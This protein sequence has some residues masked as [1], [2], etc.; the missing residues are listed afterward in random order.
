MP[1]GGLYDA[2]NDHDGCGVALVAR[3]GG[4]PRREVVV[5][6]LES[7]RNLEHRGAEG[8][9]ADTGGGAGI[10]VQVPDGFSPAASG[11]ACPRSAA[12]ACSSRSF[13]ASHAAAARAAAARTSRRAEHPRL[14]R[15]PL[16][17]APR[18]PSRARLRAG[19]RSAL[20]RGFRGHRRHEGLRAT[21]ARRSPVRRNC[22]GRGAHRPELLGANHQL[23]GP[24]HGFAARPLL[25]RFARPALRVR[26][27]LGPFRVF[28]EHVSQLAAGPPVS[29]DGP[30]RR[31]RELAEIERL[32]EADLR[33]AKDMLEGHRERPGSAVARR[34]L[35]RSAS[36]RLAFAK[37][38]PRADEQALARE[39]WPP[40]D[41]NPIET[42]EP[43]KALG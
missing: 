1:S 18:R 10:A 21:P 24:A 26:P 14:P 23:R 40:A 16:R 5:R 13:L 35:G 17:R 37:V 33:L 11:S 39:A 38:M 2:A 25:S 41:S 32:S 4:V 22:P 29:A 27:G 31:D 6:A 12:T 34:I 8:A 7:L 3:L 42:T 28:D 20:H 15:R 43:E 19:H 9:D 36:S 30:Q